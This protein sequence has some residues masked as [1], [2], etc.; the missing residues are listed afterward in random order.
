AAMSPVVRYQ[1]G[2]DHLPGQLPHA[3]VRLVTRREGHVG[4]LPLAPAPGSLLAH[5]LIRAGEKP[6]IG[7]RPIAAAFG[8]G[9][10]FHETV[11]L[12]RKYSPHVPG[13]PLRLPPPP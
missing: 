10:Q 6:G 5:R 4:V 9:Q 8:L 1:P 12:T 3:E 11:P 2:E 13:D 7:R